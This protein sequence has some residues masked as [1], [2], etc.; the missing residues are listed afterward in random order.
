MQ[1][2]IDDELHIERTIDGQRTEKQQADGATL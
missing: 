2:K 1:G